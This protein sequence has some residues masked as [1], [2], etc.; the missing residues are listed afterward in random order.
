MLWDA[1]GDD[2]DGG[3]TKS[4]GGFKHP[5]DRPPTLGGYAYAYL[6]T[7]TTYY[8]HVQKNFRVFSSPRRKKHE[9]GRYHT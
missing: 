5:A 7:V 4:P 2:G 3:V 6:L 8:L 9:E 1:G